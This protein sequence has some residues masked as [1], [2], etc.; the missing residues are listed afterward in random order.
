[1]T[2]TNKLPIYES[3]EY[4]NMRELIEDVAIRFADRTA[5]SYR[6]NPIPFPPVFLTHSFVMI[7]ALWE[8]SS[9]R[10]D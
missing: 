4:V 10:V 3:K 9:W 2:N 6:K 1:M 8:P 5:F 7:F